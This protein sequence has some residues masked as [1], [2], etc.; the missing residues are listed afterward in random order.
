[1]GRW[2]SGGRDGADDQ[3]ISTVGTERTRQQILVIE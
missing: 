1:M 2:P 3:D